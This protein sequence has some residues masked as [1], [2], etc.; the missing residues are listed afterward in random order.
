MATISHQKGSGKS[1][2]VKL[3]KEFTIIC[4]KVPKF[5]DARKNSNKEAKPQ[6]YFVKMA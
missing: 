5:R 1:L 6:G 2:K 4:L 3:F